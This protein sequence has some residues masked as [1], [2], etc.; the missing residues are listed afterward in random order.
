M[1]CWGITKIETDVRETRALR[2]EKKF[3]ARYLIQFGFGLK[4]QASK[5]LPN[6]IRFFFTSTDLFSLDLQTL[7]WTVAQ[8]L[9]NLFDFW[10]L[11]FQKRGIKFWI[12]NFWTS[13]EDCKIFL[14]CFVKSIQPSWTR[15]G[16]WVFHIYD[17]LQPTIAWAQIPLSCC[18]SHMSN[19]LFSPLKNEWWMVKL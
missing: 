12:S 17:L 14:L 4:N 13:K 2:K 7:N 8:Y 19:N 15:F 10:F 18:K 11:V 5:H 9:F 1:S 3:L 6:F 16:L